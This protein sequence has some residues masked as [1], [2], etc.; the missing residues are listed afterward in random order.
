MKVMTKSQGLQTTWKFGMLQAL[1]ELEAQSQMLQICW[2]E[3]VLQALIEPPAKGQTLKAVWQG[4]MLQALI[5]HPTESQAF[6][7]GPVHMLQRRVESVAKRQAAKI[8]R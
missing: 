6:E 5:E 7:T 1:I 3:H 4:H 2:Q 8:F